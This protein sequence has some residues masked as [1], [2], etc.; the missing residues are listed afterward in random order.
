MNETALISI[1]AN[2]IL[3]II[4]FLLKRSLDSNDKRTDALEK[5]ADDQQKELHTI[6]EMMP[7]MY[8][9]RDDFGKLGD[10]IFSALRRIE[11]KLDQKV[12]K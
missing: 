4:A 7:T 12:D 5:Q 2:V 10:N 11:D 6:R 3:A 8:V 1:F 9:R